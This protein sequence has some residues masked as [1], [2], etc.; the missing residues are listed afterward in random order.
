[1]EGAASP[2]YEGQVCFGKDL[3]N[4]SEDEIISEGICLDYLIDAYN[5]YMS[6]GNEA[7][8]FGN[9]DK[10]GK[11]WIDY[12][13]GSDELRNCIVSGMTSEEIKATWAQG[14]ADFGKQREPYLLYGD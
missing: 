12:L 9:P 4:K 1:M 8:F 11:Y 13:S 5:D 10:A 6:T 2:L 14:I 3:R 7:D